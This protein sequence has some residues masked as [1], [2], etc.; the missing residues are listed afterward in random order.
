MC[1]ERIV[2]NEA[3]FVSVQVDPFHTLFGITGL[4]LLG[5]GNV[6][7]VSPVFCMPQEVLN[8]INCKAQLL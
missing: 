8:R 2:I 7:A 6:K 5:Y 1:L 4:S 3:N